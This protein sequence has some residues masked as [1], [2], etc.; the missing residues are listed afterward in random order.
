MAGNLTGQDGEDSFPA[1]STF[2]L[3]NRTC[4]L[5]LHSCNRPCA[6]ALLLFVIPRLSDVHNW[7]LRNG[8]FIIINMVGL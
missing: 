7:E 3:T 1:E 8:V 6:L 4:C 2:S 5:L